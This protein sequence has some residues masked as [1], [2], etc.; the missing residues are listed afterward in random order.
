MDDIWG[1]YEPECSSEWIMS[2]KGKPCRILRIQGDYTLI[3]IYDTGW[4]IRG[5]I[6]LSCPISH[7]QIVG[8]L[9]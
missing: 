3:R 8:S 4:G 1:R 5:G 6:V 2:L 9:E 7:I